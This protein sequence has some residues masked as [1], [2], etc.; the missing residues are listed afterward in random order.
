MFVLTVNIVSCT[1]TGHKQFATFAPHPPLSPLSPEKQLGK[2]GSGCK[3]AA[4]CPK[5]QRC[6]CA[7][8]L[9]IYAGVSLSRRDVGENAAFRPTHPPLPLTPRLH[10]LVCEQAKSAA[11]SHPQED[12]STLLAFIGQIWQTALQ[13]YGPEQPTGLQAVAYL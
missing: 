8:F 11:L 10:L 13:A 1:G 3:Q 5:C 12:G 2:L 9:L 6:L 7:Y 4:L